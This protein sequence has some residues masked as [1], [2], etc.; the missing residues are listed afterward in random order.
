MERGW[1]GSDLHNFVL[2]EIMPLVVL[3]RELPD[4]AIRELLVDFEVEV[5]A[6]AEGKVYDEEDIVQAAEGA[7]ALITVLSDPITRPVIER[8]GSVKIISQFAV[9]YDNIDTEAAAERGIVV[10]NTPDALTDATADLAMGLLL[11]VA[12]R[13]READEYVREGRFKR[14]ETTTLLGRGLREKTLGV[15][16]MGRIGAAVARR[17]LGFGM[18]VIYHN[19][20]RANP[21]TERETC[22]RYVSFDELIEQSDVLSLHASLNPDSRYLIDRE[23]LLRMKPGSIIINTARGPILSE[24]A[25]VE[26]LA[27]RHIAGAGLD[28][29]EDEPRV[30]PELLRAPNVLLAPHLGSATV[31]ARTEMAAMCGRAVAAFLR[32]EPTIPNRVI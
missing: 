8:I 31:E 19:R 12:R 5:R 13:L 3:T 30:H 24:S 25:L 15:L 7:D 4:E 17:A 2:T 11:G 22:A 26:M 28:V 18:R 27:T 32:G 9:G 21:T 23:V 20:R 10:T 6:P 29:F 16:G 1:R 14:W